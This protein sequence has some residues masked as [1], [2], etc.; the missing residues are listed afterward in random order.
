MSTLH[1]SACQDKRRPDLAQWLKKISED[2]H[3]EGDF[4]VVAVIAA[5]VVVVVVVVVVAVAV[6]AV[7]AAAHRARKVSG[8]A[9]SQGRSVRQCLLQLGAAESL[10]SLLWRCLNVFCPA[11]LGVWRRAAHAMVPGSG[12]TCVPHDSTVP[13]S[14]NP[15]LVWNE[16]SLL[17]FV[18]S[19][20]KHAQHPKPDSGDQS[21]GT[22]CLFSPLLLQVVE[23]PGLVEML[24]S[25]VLWR[26]KM[27]TA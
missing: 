11:D 4:R 9:A 24:R 7:V 21:E 19:Y 14:G 22:S 15:D 16:V 12:M 5:V 10:G 1:I 27:G 26:A 3:C 25:C 8:A 20:R 6:A 13:Q 17:L 23:R 2:P 18:S